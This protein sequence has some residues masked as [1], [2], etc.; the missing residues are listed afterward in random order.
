[1]VFYSISNAEAVE[2]D[3]IFITSCDLTEPAQTSLVQMKGCVI[4]NNALTEEYDSQDRYNQTRKVPFWKK[5]LCC[6]PCTEMC[7][8]YIW[9][10]AVR[11]AKFAPNTCVS[12]RCCF[13]LDKVCV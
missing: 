12:N 8:D 2:D 11:C 1:M 3:E 6:H 7:N 5:Y 13:L 9:I 10:L 4:R